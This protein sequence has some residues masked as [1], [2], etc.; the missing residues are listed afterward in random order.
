MVPSR[1][2]HFETVPFC[3]RIRKLTVTRSICYLVRGGSSTGTSTNYKRGRKRV[4]IIFIRVM[5]SARAKKME[6]EK[7]EL[8]DRPERWVMTHTENGW[9][10]LKKCY[11]AHL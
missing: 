4:D 1:I 10:N 2:S 9:Q 3:C 7:K 6:G 11:Y 8:A 5:S